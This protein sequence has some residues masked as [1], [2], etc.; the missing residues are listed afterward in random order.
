MAEGGREKPV[1]LRQRSGTVVALFT[2][3]GTFGALVCTALGDR[4]GRRRLIFTAAAVAGVGSILM[5]TSYSFAHFIIAQIV[6]RLGTGG[7]NTTVSL[8]HANHPV[9]RTY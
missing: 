9:V 8:V 1:L 2:L 5:A 6:T 4:L 7:I 3:C